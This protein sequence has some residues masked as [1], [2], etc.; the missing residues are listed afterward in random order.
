MEFFNNYPFKHFLTLNLLYNN[1]YGDYYYDV[2]EDII[3]PYS[4]I[5][6]YNN[7][8]EY[9]IS[10]T[11]RLVGKIKTINN[12]YKT[13]NKSIK[14]EK[15]IIPEIPSDVEKIINNHNLND[16]FINKLYELDNKIKN[17]NIINTDLNNN[18]NINN[19]ENVNNIKNNEN[20]NNVN[21]VNNVENNDNITYNLKVKFDLYND[22]Q[23]SELLDIINNKKIA[24]NQI[25]NY[26]YKYYNNKYDIKN[27]NYEELLELLQEDIYNDIENIY[28]NTIS[29][30]FIDY[31]IRETFNK[32]YINNNLQ[33]D[34]KI[35]NIDW[36]YIKH[37]NNIII[38]N[39][40][41][42]TN[43]DN[44]YIIELLFDKLKYNNNDVNR[45]VNGYY[46]YSLFDV[47]SNNDT[48]K[49]LI[50]SKLFDIKFI[51]FLK[52]YNKLGYGDSI[53]SNINIGNINIELIN[54]N[55]NSFVINI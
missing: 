3:I 12:L 2:D 39:L 21:D 5:D 38:Y 35:D 53:I 19:N 26:I 23:Q 50:D 44:I 17:N 25:V 32:E 4:E 6:K 45:L 46:I 20:V 13:I 27:T 7:K 42:N 15:I 29:K 40:S 43:I 16:P 54:S 11:Y 24:Y 47:D 36:K 37:D 55:I 33:Y 52:L 10:K 22:G 14:S 9:R 18:I 8:K 1:N 28:F 30:I 49:E 48:I 34:Y 41:I 51:D 31:V